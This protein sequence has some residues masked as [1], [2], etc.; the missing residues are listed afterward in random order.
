MSSLRLV[1][2]HVYDWSDRA[3][4]QTFIGAAQASPEAAAATATVGCHPARLAHRAIQALRQ[5]RLQMRRRPWSRPEVLPVGE[6]SRR[7]AP[8]G[9]RA[10][11]RAGRDPRAGGQ[12][13]SGAQRSGRDLR[14]QPRAITAPR[15]AVRG[16]GERSAPA[17]HRID[18]QCGRRAAHGQHG[19]DVARCRAMLS[20]TQGGGR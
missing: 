7:T 15:G 3:I 10:A 11:G 18:R 16:C 12:L 13:P 19:G 1:S 8:D 9:L 20:R 5:A 6:L 2:D 4:R 14:D 17:A